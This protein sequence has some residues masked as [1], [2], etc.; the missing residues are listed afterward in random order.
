[1]LKTIR[2]AWSIPDLRKKLLFTLMIIIVF[3]IGSVIP[4][5]FLDMSALATAM[6]GM[7]E[8][9]TMLAYLNTLSGG[10][11]ANATLFAMGVTPYINSSII[12]QLLT[13]AIPPLE[14]MAKEGEAGR[15]KIGTIT[16]YV[17][18]GLGLVQGG[19]YWYYLHKSGVTVYTE[20]FSLVFSAIV[21]I[22][23]FTAGTALM[24]WLGEQIN[25][26]GIGNGISILLFAGIVAQLPYTLSMLGQFWKLAGEGSTQFYFLV[27]LWIVIFVAIVWVITFMQDS[28]RRIPIQYAKRVV[29]RKM[30][31]G[32]SSHL[33]IK[34]ALG[35]VLPIIFAS[36]ILSIPG[37]INLFAKV[38]D[39]FW[40]AFF[41]AFDTSG[42]LYNVLYFIL[43]IMFA[44]FY[45][46]IQ[47]NPIEMANNL[48]SNN[49]TIPGIRPGAP[50]ADYIRNILSRI[51]LIGALFLAVI[52]LV[53]SIYGSATG[54]GRM[55]IGGTSIIILVGVALETVKQ[56]ESQMMMRHYK[57]F[58][59]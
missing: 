55:A 30:Y 33:P 27:P 52:A 17:T 28:E 50:T 46:T 36:S 7:N 54:M 40:G 24:M 47:Y 2:N 49:G 5:P 19:A 12:M 48:K 18:V 58:L 43:I 1:M 6:N 9:N 21:I 37:T 31:G 20:G 34:V 45:T 4:V 44:Y 56:L 11:F 57:G 15:R 26:N 10:A 51:T 22:L 32:Q 25:T 3:R 14:R 29:G 13:V 59:D 42:W 35:G 53:P 38:K 23:V 8:G 41:N 16:R 39:G